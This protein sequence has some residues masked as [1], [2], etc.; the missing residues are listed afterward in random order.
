MTEKEHEEE[1]TFDTVYDDDGREEMATNDEISPEE[2][3]F[4]K[5]YD[6]A[7]EEESDSKADHKLEKSFD[8]EE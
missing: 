4:M 8:E 3:A 1:D 7:E 6:E 2:E 5:G